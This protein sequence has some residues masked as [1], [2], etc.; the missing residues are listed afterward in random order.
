MKAFL[1]KEW[2]EWLR[3]GRLMVLLMVFVLLGIMS[4]A[5]AK[6]TPWLMETLSDS[7]A[8]TGI[9]TTEIT[10]DAM[11]SWAQFYKN[12]PM[13]LVIFVL[14]CSGSFTSEYQKGTL[15]LVVTRG[16][17]RK[18][19]AAAKMILLSGLW[20]GCPA[21]ASLAQKHCFC[22]GHGRRCIGSVLGLRMG[23][24]PISGIMVLQGTCFLQGLVIG[25][26]AFGWLQSWRLFLLLQGAARRCCP[27]RAERPL[28][29]ICWAYSQH[30]ILSFRQ[31]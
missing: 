29:F 25:C 30:S 27:G 15:V 10:V 16:L 19:T 18:K 28:A 13:G 21:G 11:V 22:L 8:G 14:L 20:T 9:V 2:M 1:K 7:M 5:L 17:S 26:L 3:T 31:N 12:I 6:L 4:P 23:T 24:M